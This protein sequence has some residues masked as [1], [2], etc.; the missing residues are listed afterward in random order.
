[1]KDHVEEKM[2][3]LTKYAHKIVKVHVVMEVQ[4]LSQKCEVNLEAKHLH[5]NASAESKNMYESISKCLDK[6]VHQIKHHKLHFTDKNHRI[7]TKEF[8]EEVVAMEQLDV[9]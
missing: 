2:E 7:A 6:L 3:V 4:N 8:E 9:A 5:L 1:M